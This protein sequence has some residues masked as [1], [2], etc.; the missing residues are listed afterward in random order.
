MRKKRDRHL[1]GIEWTD[2]EVR[3]LITQWKQDRSFA[4]IARSIGRSR[5]SVTIKA[6]RL[7][8]TTRPYWNDQYLAK[9][10]RSGS[11]RHCMSCRHMFF[12]EG[13]GNRI[14]PQCKNRK[15][16]RSGGDF[17]APGH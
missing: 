5:K 12:S 8:L 16:W 7:G 1:N 15:I 11:A 13:S 17:A 14:C 2:E 6:C 9:A 4:K 3:S 10:K